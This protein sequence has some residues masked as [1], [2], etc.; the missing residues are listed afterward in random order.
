MALG[1]PA[2]L[3]LVLPGPDPLTA[4]T[5][6][7]LGLPTWGMGL[8]WHLPLGAVEGVGEP[9]QLLDARQPGPELALG[10]PPRVSRLG[11]S[12]VR[13]LAPCAPR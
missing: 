13:T 8:R 7:S 5:S 12:P 1:W 4:G 2:G 9:S 11:P 3:V 10:S 6:P